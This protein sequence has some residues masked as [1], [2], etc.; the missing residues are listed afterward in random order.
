MVGPGGGWWRRGWSVGLGAAIP[1]VALLAYNVATTGQVFH[2]AYDH[3]YQLEARAYTGLGYHPDWAAEDPRYLPQNL[4]I[5]WLSAPDVLPDRLRD[6]LGTMDRPLCVTPATSRG[7]F[8]IGLSHRGPARHRHERAAHQPRIAA[9]HPRPVRST[10]SAPRALR[11][12][13]SCSYRSRTSCISVRAGCSSAIASATTR[14]HSPG[15]RGDRL[16]LAVDRVRRPPGRCRR[17]GSIVLSVASTLG[18]SGSDPRMVSEPSARG[19]RRFSSGSAPS[20]DPVAMSRSR[21]LGYRRAAGGRAGDGDR[22]SDGL[23]DYFLSA[24]QPTSCCRRSVNRPS[25]DL[26]AG[27][28]VAVAAASGR[29]GPGIHRSV[30]LGVMAGVGLALTGL[31]WSI[32]THA[33]AM[34]HSPSSRSLRAGRLGGR[35]PRSDPRAGGRG[36]RLGP[37]TTR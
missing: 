5:M 10:A 19:S 21:L 15:A 32:G 25:D 9:G 30:T 12:S 7:L 27:L 28:S 35:P 3:L 24:G 36:V 23:P 31:V 18:W 2:P 20:R 37:A 6:T 11:S 26:F 33:E 8:D 1:V 16:R 22:A 17:V 34:P 14:W 4:R 13:R 29:P